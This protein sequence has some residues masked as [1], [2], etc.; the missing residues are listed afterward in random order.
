MA[1]S[2]YYAILPIGLFCNFYKEHNSLKLDQMLIV[3]VIVMVELWA[4]QTNCRTANSN[5]V[6]VVSI[7]NRK[8][9]S[10][11][12][13]HVSTRNAVKIYFQK[14]FPSH[15]QSWHPLATRRPFSSPCCWSHS[16]TADL[17]MY[18]HIYTVYKQQQQQ[19]SFFVNNIHLLTDLW[20]CAR[21]CV[22]VSTG[23]AR[24]SV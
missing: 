5:S 10:H 18:V 11:H 12:R 6:P 4:V 21:V 17:S 16:W 14:G 20:L 8:W 24:A 2:A 13:T 15:L 3:A 19:P 7:A 23:V 9:C 22:D 1:S